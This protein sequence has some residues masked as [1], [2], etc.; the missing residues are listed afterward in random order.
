[1]RRYSEQ[2]HSGRPAEGEGWRLHA[3][4]LSAAG[5]LTEEEMATNFMTSAE[6]EGR[7]LIRQWRNNHASQYFSRTAD[8][9]V[10]RE[11]LEMTSRTVNAYCQRHGFRIRELPGNKARRLAL[12]RNLQPPLH[13]QGTY[14]PRISAAGAVYLDA[15]AYI[16]DW[17]LICGII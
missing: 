5:R 6:F 12:A 17:T 11:M 4:A 3:E 16:S 13:V 7:G 8:P 15:D 9:V 10:Y 2:G 1:M 14:G